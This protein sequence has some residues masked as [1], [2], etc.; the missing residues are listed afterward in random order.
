MKGEARLKGYQKEREAEGTDERRLKGEG[1][2][3]DA[4]DDDGKW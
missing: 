1:N 2:E 3:E 4:D